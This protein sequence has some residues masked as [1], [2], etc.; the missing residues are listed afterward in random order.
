MR[1]VKGLNQPD[2]KMQELRPP[3]HAVDQDPALGHRVDLALGGGEAVRGGGYLAPLD[4]HQLIPIEDPRLLR[5]PIWKDL[6]DDD[7]V[8]SPIDLAHLNRLQLPPAL[9]IGI[10]VG[11]LVEVEG[12]QGEHEGQ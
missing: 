4:G 10:G 1:P 5:N 8:G 12:S 6:A 11:P 3:P 7:P 2:G 9:V